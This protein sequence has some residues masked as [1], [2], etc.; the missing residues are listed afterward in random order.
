MPLLSLKDRQPQSHHKSFFNSGGERDWVYEWIRASD[1]AQDSFLSAE[2]L[3]M[4]AFI[5]NFD[6]GDV[7]SSGFLLKQILLIS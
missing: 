2:Y 3:D 7:A 5:L 1:S 6:C 4:G